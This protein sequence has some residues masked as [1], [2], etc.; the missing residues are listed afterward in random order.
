[1]RDAMFGLVV[2]I[3]VSLATGVAFAV[4]VLVAVAM[5]SAP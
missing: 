3:V 1:M 5:G 4:L 2:A